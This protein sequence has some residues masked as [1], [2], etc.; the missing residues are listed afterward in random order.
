MIEHWL[1]SPHDQIDTS[2]LMDMKKFTRA[3]DTSGFM[4]AL[5]TRVAET[6]EFRVS[7]LMSQH[8]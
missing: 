4:A 6:I 3:V 5:A 2:V 8:E 7:C 1:A